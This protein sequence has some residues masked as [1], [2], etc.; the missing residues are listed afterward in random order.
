[1][2]EDGDPA[3]GTVLRR[4]PFA[5]N[6]AVGARGQRTQQRILDA[7]LQ[8]FGEAGYHSTSM[9]RI[10]KVAGCSRVSVYQYFAGKEDVFRHLAAEVERE[11]TASTEALGPVTADAEGWAALRAWV[12]RHGEVYARYEPV[13]LAFRAAAESDAE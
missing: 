13:F 1:M 8:V 12:G 2:T 7:A 9:E 11:V 6:P 4:A 3:A 10:A 5:D